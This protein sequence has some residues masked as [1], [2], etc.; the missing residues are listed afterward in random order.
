M[1]MHMVFLHLLTNYSAG[2]LKPSKPRWASST[3][4]VVIHLSTIIVWV[5]GLGWGGGVEWA[6]NQNC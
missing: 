5:G 6:L 4:L 2:S 1:Y 3:Y